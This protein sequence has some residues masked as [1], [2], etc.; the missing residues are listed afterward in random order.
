[1]KKRMFKVFIS[2]V[3]AI[4][5]ASSA[6]L[7]NACKERPQ[8]SLSAHGQSD[9]RSSEQ[10]N[11]RD[12]EQPKARR[13]TLEQRSGNALADETKAPDLVHSKDFKGFWGRLRDSSRTDNFNSLPHNIET[14][15][16]EYPTEQ[17]GKSDIG[18]EY[19]IYELGNGYRA[20]LLYG[21]FVVPG[22]QTQKGFG[23]IAGRELHSH[24]D[25]ETL[26]IGDPIENV[27]KIDIIA[28][29]YREAFTYA[30]VPEMAAST[31]EYGYPIASIHYLSDG[32]LKIE[33][34]M[35][36]DR[37]LVISNI[38]YAPDYVLVNPNGEGILHYIDPVDLP[39]A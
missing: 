37:S 6:V 8:F 21:D 33:Y 9:I 16:Q 11:L 17:R 15:L 12:T 10:Q 24:K 18:L 32:I 26:K 29:T 38:V 13:T 39:K 36:D 27:E 34:E 22:I 3:L 31:A 23:I 28:Q 7:F 20:Y 5:I 25:F 19:L 14:I 30:F 1:M 2:L 4:L 35:K